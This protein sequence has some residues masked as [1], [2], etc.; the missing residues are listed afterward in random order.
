VLAAA[1]IKLVVAVSLSKQASFCVR[2]F[3]GAAMRFSRCLAWIFGILLPIAETVRR[4]ATWQEFPPAL[5]DDYSGGAA[6]GGGVVRRPRRSAR[7]ALALW[8]EPGVAD[9]IIS[10]IDMHSMLAETIDI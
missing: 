5:F 4:W 9:K 7:P 8:A 10:R 2:Q 1:W 6:A 3:T